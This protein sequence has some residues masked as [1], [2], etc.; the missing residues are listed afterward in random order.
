MAILRSE[1]IRLEPVSIKE[2]SKLIKNID[3]NNAIFKFSTLH[4]LNEIHQDNMNYKV[5]NDNVSSN[6]RICGLSYPITPLAK[7]ATSLIS[8]IHSSSKL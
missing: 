5:S 1:G 6:L 3:E 7:L 4:T 2:W 8:A